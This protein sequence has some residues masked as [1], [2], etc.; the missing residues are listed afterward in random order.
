[1]SCH[2]PKP[3]SPNPYVYSRADLVKIAE[4]CGITN[5]AKKNMTILCDEIMNHTPNSRHIVF[6]ERKRSPS[7]PPLSPRIQK[8]QKPHIRQPPK[9]EYKV[10][11]ED[12]LINE[13]IQL[14]IAPK[15]GVS[16]TKQHVGCTDLSRIAKYKNR[17]SP[18]YPANECGGKTF[19]GN[20]GKLW[21]SIANVRG[22]YTW[23][24]IY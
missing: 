9:S 12:E 21:Q 19:I 22:I 13:L 20:D 15:R 17:P 3:C 16:S 2:L 18:P 1:M 10:Y 24:R 4:A 7:P 8:P 14:S 23:R 6:E 5:V 11:D